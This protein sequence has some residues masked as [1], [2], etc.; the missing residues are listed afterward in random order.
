[1]F[2]LV[3]SQK[4]ILK[5]NQTIDFSVIENPPIFT[6]CEKITNKR[7]C[8]E[9]S[10]VN[11]ISKH[12]IYPKD[13][14]E[15]AIQ[16]IVLVNFIVEKNGTFSIK[17]IKSPHLLLEKEVRRIFKILPKVKPGNHKGKMVRMEMNI[18]ISFN[19]VEK[20]TRNFSNDNEEFGMIEDPD[21]EAHFL[22]I[23]HVPLFKGCENEVDKRACFLKNID[24]HIAKNLIYPL[25]AKEK[26]IQGNVFVSF[27][28]EKNGSIT[29]NNVIGKNPI[30]EKEARRVMELLPILTPGTQRGKP[31]RM[32]M[33]KK[34]SFKL[35]E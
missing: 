14:E 6:N 29:I 21:D 1:M 13:A 12:K 17:N 27:F 4:N 8:F 16:G 24:E 2:S 22:I 31:A 34:I 23:E 30:L 7:D 10:I 20:V 26:K 35:E 11:H 5:E 3:F 32:T 9:E 15:R 33:G 28:I 25:E 19:Q 18:N